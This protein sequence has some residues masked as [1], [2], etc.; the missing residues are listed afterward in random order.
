MEPTSATAP[1]LSLWETRHEVGVR[2]PAPSGRAD[3]VV[4]GAGL[5]GLVTAL[6]LARAGK[7][8][9]V[10]EARTV[11]ALASGRNTG[12]VSLLQGTRLSQLLS[13]H[14]GTVA[15]A[16][17]E[18]NREGMDWLLRFCEDHEVAQHPRSAVTYAANPAEVGLVDAEHAAAHSLGLPTLRQPTVDVPFP[19]HAAVVLQNQAEVDPQAVLI[20]LADQAA[21]HGGV[22]GEGQ[23]VVDVSWSSHPT[24]R[25]DDGATFRTED[26]V[27]ATGSPIL[28]RGLYFA[29]LEA[30]RSYLLT[31][32]GA[33]V[34][35]AMMISAGQDA[36]SV[37]DVPDGERLLM[38]GGSGHQV[39]HGRPEL[40]HVEELRAWVAEHFPDAVETH[41]WSAQDYASHDGIPYVGKL[42]RGRG[43]VWLASGYDKWGLSN[44]PSAG[45]RIASGILGGSLPWARPLERRI[46]HPRAAFE[47]LRRNLAIGATAVARLAGAEASTLPD[48]APQRVGEVGRR[49]LDPR[50]VGVVS[51]ECAVRAVCT[52]LGGTLRWN[53]AERSWDCPLH[54]SRFTEDGEVLEGPA[55]SPLARIHP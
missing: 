51:Q 46:T 30:R 27:L 47:L 3:V 22:I 31:F 42:P 49:G 13:V 50:P 21:V 52:H 32:S 53:D 9:V 23:R 35:E 8:V 16:Y 40:D 20:A 54:G 28:D 33:L 19:V 39:G 10:L 36:R 1:A 26:V 15:A 45:L 29:K 55:V 41:A 2:P 44:A 4:V 18:G 24:V 5:T 7:Q 43:A 6:L 37:R 48:G 12:K 11:G 34:P 25:T 38:V 14:S 17:L